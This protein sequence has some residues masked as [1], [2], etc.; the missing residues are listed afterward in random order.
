MSEEQ[1]PMPNFE[2]DGSPHVIS[3]VETMEVTQGV[4]CDVYRFEG[5]NTR[6]LGIVR[7]QPGHKT[8]LQRVMGGERTIEGYVSGKGRFVVIRPDLTTQVYL[9]DG[10]IEGLQVE[11]AVGEIV[12]YFA[13]E[14]S[15]LVASEICYPPYED[16]RFENIEEES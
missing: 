12:Q 7:I 10:S 4:E 9:F 5:D 2:I 6:D 1:P 8:H 13:D 3:F 14:D 15:N 16:G 11:L